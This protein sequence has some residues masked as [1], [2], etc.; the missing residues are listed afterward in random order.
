MLE[1]RAPDIVRA[2]YRGLLRREPEP[3][4]LQ[5]SAAKL[6]E[7]HDMAS[8]LAGLSRSDEMWK[9]Q[10][11]VRA[12]QLVE[13]MYQ[14]LLEREADSLGL[15]TYSSTITELNGVGKVL[16]TIVGSVE[17]IKQ[18]QR[19]GVVFLHIQKTAGTS[20][21]TMMRDFLGKEFYGEHAD[22]LNNHTPRK[23]SAFSAFSGHFNHDSLSFIPCRRLVVFTFVREPKERLVS[24]YYFWRAHEPTAPA[25]GGGQKIANELLI[26]EFFER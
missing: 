18:Q 21:Q 13:S 24:H 15:S 11:A 19:L 4:V 22:S 25:W 17:F 1:A 23:L 14:S 9:Q 2:M 3:E 20:I 7:T 5:A 26:E 12:P 16:S 10:L 8:A 6:S